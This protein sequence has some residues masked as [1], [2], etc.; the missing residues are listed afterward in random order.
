MIT[1][2]WRDFV[3]S[4]MGQIKNTKER[5]NLEGEGRRV[6]RD[7]FE[8]FGEKFENGNYRPW[9]HT[10][11]DNQSSLVYPAPRRDRKAYFSTPKPAT[12][13]AIELR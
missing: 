4:L 7:Y 13:G 3:V 2:E 12:S 9:R 8:K 5:F 1:H 11:L 6:T 10:H